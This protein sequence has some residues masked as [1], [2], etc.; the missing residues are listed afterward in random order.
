M[1]FPTIR[2]ENKES[3]EKLLIKQNFSIQRKAAKLP[4]KIAF[5]FANLQT[6]Q[7][8]ANVLQTVHIQTIELY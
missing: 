4:Y 7:N 6:V 8:F 5:C 1:Q 3:M 2:W